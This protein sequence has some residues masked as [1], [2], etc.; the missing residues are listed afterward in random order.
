MHLLM[1][2]YDGAAAFV[3]IIFCAGLFFRLV[4][5]PIYYFTHPKQ[6][7]AQEHETK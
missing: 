4:Y 6:L 7:E 1:Q 2:I 5:E 3:G